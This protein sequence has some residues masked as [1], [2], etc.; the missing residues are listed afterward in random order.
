MFKLV[1]LRCVTFLLIQLFSFSIYA[2]QKQLNGKIYE[3]SKSKPFGQVSILFVNNSN[4]ILNAY[5]SES[6]GT[7]NI[8]VPTNAVKVVFSTVGFVK[9]EIHL[10]TIIQPLD[11]IMKAEDLQ[12][13]EVEVVAKIKPD[14][15]LGFVNINKR[16]LS[17]SI[18][19]ID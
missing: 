18:A 14:A 9:Q 11:I 8:N 13:E 12:I 1:Q 16:E 3:E 19:S 10:A 17:S 6:D 5:K 2:Q 7:F 4:L 15:D